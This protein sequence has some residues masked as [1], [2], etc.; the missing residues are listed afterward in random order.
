MFC[1]YETC[2][3]LLVWECDPS[4]E[5]LCQF[6]GTTCYFAAGLLARMFDWRRKKD[7]GSN[8]M[9]NSMLRNEL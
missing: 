3:N 7:Q 1:V 5:D 2:I 9:R 8:H 4:Y 6:W